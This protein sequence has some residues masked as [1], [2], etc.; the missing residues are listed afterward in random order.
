M[1]EQRLLDISKTITNL[2]SKKVQLNE[3]EK[4]IIA[5]QLRVKISEVLLVIFMFFIAFCCS[6]KHWDFC[7]SYITMRFSRSYIGGIHRKTFWGCCLH[8]CIFFAV[9]LMCA[10]Y[11]HVLRSEIMFP[12][13]CYIDARY[14]PCPSKER[15]QYGKRARMRMKVFAFLGL[16]FC[17][18]LCVTL[19]QYRNIILVTLTM[20]HIEFVVKFIR[21]RRQICLN[22]YADIS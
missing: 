13:F 22:G 15:G 5:Y 16:L 8:T 17:L 18:L 11:I 12:L 19:P 1:M 6:K 3:D 2:L 4:E 21:E 14:A 20:V 10:E 9:A 7:V